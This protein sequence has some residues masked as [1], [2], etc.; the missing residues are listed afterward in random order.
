VELCPIHNEFTIAHKASNVSN[1]DD[2]TIDA[3]AAFLGGNQLTSYDYID[4][5][6]QHFT[7]NIFKG[8]AT[9]HSL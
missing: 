1:C 5:E 4:N 7:N 8:L 3:L 2:K 9:T 6:T